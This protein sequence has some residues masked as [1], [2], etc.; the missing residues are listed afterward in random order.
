M[1]NT[2]TKVIQMRI[3]DC[4]V[5][6][7]TFAMPDSFYRQQQ[8]LGKQ[9]NFYCPNGHQMHFSRSILQQEVDRLKSENDSLSKSR[10]SLHDQLTE[11]VHEIDRLNKSIKR[12][13]RRLKA[14][15]CPC[16]NRTFK[17]LAAHMKTEHPDYSELLKPVKEIHKK[18]SKKA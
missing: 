4:C 14:G 9:A 18:I 7:I 12:R 15:V 1:N 13:N 11:K 3:T 2:L 17:E 16:C 6:G 5:C 10:T 8:E